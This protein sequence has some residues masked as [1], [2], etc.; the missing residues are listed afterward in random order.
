M[1]ELAP[2]ALTMPQNELP[3]GEFLLPV[4]T[5]RE[6]L[7]ELFNALKLAE[8]Y[9]ES[10]DPRQKWD[11][12]EAMAHID[13]PTSAPCFPSSNCDEDTLSDSVFSFVDEII[14]EFR[15]GGVSKAVGYVIDQL[16]RIVVTTALKTIAITV[17]GVA[18]AGILNILVGGVA[19]GTIAVGAGEAVETILTLDPT[20]P[21]NI[22]EFVFEKV[23]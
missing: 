7:Q 6:R 11:I 16:G 14:E 10:L 8:I 18:T 4:C 22:I 23:A 19:V 12:L 21:S 1:A 3:D 9:A 20:I 15:E 17:L 2:Y 5:S 13:D